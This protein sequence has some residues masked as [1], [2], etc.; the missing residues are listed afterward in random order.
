MPNIL[1]NFIIPNTPVQ[2]TSLDWGWLSKV[3]GR[4]LASWDPCIEWFLRLRLKTPLRKAHA[5][6]LSCG[7]SPVLTK[8][9]KAVGSNCNTLK[10]ESKKYSQNLRLARKQDLLFQQ[11]ARCAS[12]KEEGYLAAIHQWWS[13]LLGNLVAVVNGAVH[14]DW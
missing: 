3:S 8:G 7:L 10:L 9:Q 4:S 5:L 14:W 11:H 1:S 12:S 13:L 2:I 6:A